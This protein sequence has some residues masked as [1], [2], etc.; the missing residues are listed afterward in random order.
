MVRAQ[1]LEIEGVGSDCN[2]T[3]C[4]CVIWG[5]LPHLSVTL[6]SLSVK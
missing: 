6:V 3:S 4:N 2:P 1:A 5:K